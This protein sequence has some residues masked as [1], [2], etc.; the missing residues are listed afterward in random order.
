MD[1]GDCLKFLQID[2]LAT[3]KMSV[4]L[5][6][7]QRQQL[8]DYLANL[9]DQGRS[10]RSLARRVAAL[11]SFFDYLQKQGIVAHNPA[12]LLK[13]PKLPK[14]LPRLLD[15]DQ[16]FALMQQPQSDKILEIRDLAIFELLYSAGLRVSELTQLNVE[17]MQLEAGE[18]RVLGKG[19]KERQV[20]FGAPAQR[21]L[22][23]YLQVR[24]KL[25]GKRQSAALFLN[26][27]GGRLTPRS[28]ERHLQ[29]YLRGMDGMSTAATP[30][31]LR[32]A[33]ATHLLES[34]AD[35]R[36][37]QEMLGHAS[38]ATTQ[39]YLHV[40]LQRLT[41]VYDQAHPR[42]KSMAQPTARPSA[43]ALPAV[44]RSAVALP[45]LGRK[46]GRSR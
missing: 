8:R 23:N 40:D 10:P 35:L 14:P 25:L 11:R 24:S 22:Q 21:A 44:T 17:Q 31:S 30:H 6:Q 19:N 46:S 39:R 38:L 7:I 5:T 45:V 9:V 36:S 13:S 29:R 3:A 16:A 28:V 27:R 41:A 12:A 32:H 42:A 4:M 26:A 15:V 37:I 20:P 2:T 18:V 43:A 1:V 34:G 33:F